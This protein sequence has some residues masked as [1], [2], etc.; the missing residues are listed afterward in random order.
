[1]FG[2]VGVWWCGA[3]GFAASTGE[4]VSVRGA[5]AVRL[6]P[7]SVCLTPACDMCRCVLAPA[8]VCACVLC[9]NGVGPSLPLSLSLSF[10]AQKGRRKQILRKLASERAGVRG[11]ASQREEKLTAP[12]PQPG[13][14]TPPSRRSYAA[15]ATATATE[16]ASSPSAT[17][18][19][20]VG[21]VGATDVSADV[22]STSRGAAAVRGR[23]SLPPAGGSAPLPP[24]DISTRVAAAEADISVMANDVI[25]K[26]LS[27]GPLS[28]GLGPAAAAVSAAPPAAPAAVPPH[29][30]HYTHASAPTE[31]P[32]RV[33]A[34]PSSLSA[35]QSSRA[36]AAR[37]RAARSAAVGATAGST[38]ASA[39]TFA[40]AS[41]SV[42]RAGSDAGAVA[43][44]ASPAAG[45]SLPS[46]AAGSGRY[47]TKLSNEALIEQLLAER[48]YR[49]PPAQ[50]TGR[51]HG[52]VASSRQQPGGVQVP[53]T[54]DGAEAGST[55]HHS[56]RHE[57]RHRYV[58]GATAG[59]GVDGT[60]GPGVGVGAGAGAG[61]GAGVG[62]G[63]GVD[64]VVGAASSDGASST[65]GP[66]QPLMAWDKDS[67]DGGS[68]GEEGLDGSG[69]QLNG[70][71]SGQRFARGGGGGGGGGHSSASRVVSQRRR[72]AAG[73]KG[74]I[75]GPSSRGA[76]PAGSRGATRT[77]R[78][79]GGSGG[80]GGGGGRGSGTRTGGR[81]RGGVGVRGKRGA[82]RRGVDAEGRGTTGPRKKGLTAEEREEAR[83]R[84]FRRV[85]LG[86][87][88]VCVCVCVC[89]VCVCVVCVVGLHV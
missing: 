66:V 56:H 17:G 21:A 62:M 84:L 15:T 83:Q 71:A 44:R 14:R 76:A 72:G 1:M 81:A 22:Y 65:G 52:G 50:T 86:V 7:M 18:G 9:C 61:V 78:R 24:P 47:T 30:H 45:L 73:G 12:S 10:P 87:P 13:M 41:A 82:G 20:F 23:S 28:E 3:D 70:G 33:P 54:E 38:P 11:Y 77:A 69:G 2:R 19:Y 39:A 42:S 26:L 59:V 68:E 60:T 37:S 79:G 5:T 34:P 48:R 63:M 29:S 57:H 67:L 51:G 32:P 31:L 75:A 8:R 46:T 16:T 80:G 36:Y 74:I 85:R 58:S 53:Q 6:V 40:S 88:C 49:H 64:V 25:T 43:A 4:T 89:V 55:Q 35:S 27:A